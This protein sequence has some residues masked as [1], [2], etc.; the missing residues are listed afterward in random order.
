[1]GEEAAEGVV[2]RSMFTSKVRVRTKT[3]VEA[4]GDCSEP[5]CPS[6]LWLS[7]FLL[8]WQLLVLCFQQQ[9]S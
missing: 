3:T 2:L 8:D 6:V 4:Q 7:L 5:S 1:M 9:P